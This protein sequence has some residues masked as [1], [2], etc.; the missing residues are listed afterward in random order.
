MSKPKIQRNEMNYKYC[1]LSSGN[2]DEFPKLDKEMKK[3]RVKCDYLNL[4]SGGRIYRIAEIEFQKLPR[5]RSGYYFGDDKSGHS[6][7]NLPDIKNIQK[8]WA[9]KNLKWKNINV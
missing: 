4:N 1:I 9:G 2:A 8:E 5:D 7:Y 3:R 6:M